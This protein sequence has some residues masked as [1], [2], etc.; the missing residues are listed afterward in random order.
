MASLISRYADW[1]H[2]RWPAGRVERLPVVGAGGETRIP[3][4]YIAG[5]LA[6]VPLLKFALDTG[7]KAA[8]RCARELRGSAAAAD[9]LD[10]V[11]LGAG[12]AGMAAAIECAK[13]GLRY[14]VV[15]PSQPFTTVANF[16]ERKPIFTY[17]RK[18]RPEGTLQ[19]SA[20]VKEDLLE[21][22][23][24]QARG[25]DIPTR[26]GSADRI[27]RRGDALAVIL[28]EG[29]PLL[30]RRVIIAIGRSGNFRRLGAPGEDLGKVSN[31]LHDPKAHAGHDVLVVGGGDSA[32]EA[33]I[34]LADAGARV[35]LCHRGAELSR[36]KPENVERLRA[37]AGAGKVALK[38]GTTVA[39]IGEREVALSSQAGG[40]RL[41]NDA[42]YA[43]IGREPPLDFFRASGIPIRGERDWRSLGG[44]GA[45]L[46]FA[47]VLYGMKAFGWFGAASWNPATIAAH[48]AERTQPGSLANVVLGSATGFGFWVTLVYSAVVVGFGIA[49]IRRRR[50]P[51]VTAQTL[52]LMAVQCLPLF[53]VPEVVLPWLG[54]HGAWDSGLGAT[55]Q[56]HLFPSVDYNFHHHE[57]WRAYGLVLAWPLFVWNVFTDQPSSW[58]LAISLVQTFVLVPLIVWK[59]GKGAYCGWI[60]SCGAL[61]E[62]MGDQQREKMG[63]GPG[64]NR[65]NFVGQALLAIAMLM[66][67][68][69]IAGWIAPERLQ[70][71]NR[72]LLYHGWKP[73]VDYALAGAVGVGLY[74]HLSGRVWCRF[75]CPLAALMHI[76]ARFSKFRIVPE[77][78]KCISCNACTTSCHQGIDVMSFANRGAAMADP[79]CVR[80]SACVQ[81]C[82]TGV[83]QF[84]EVGRDGRV[85]RLDRL[86]ASPVLMREAQGEKLE[87]GKT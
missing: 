42:V 69:R 5:D 79:E 29:E 38:L 16:P 10:V 40:E 46:A 85:L 2:L 27:E 83:L 78:A 63:H 39:S 82:P 48:L 60:C 9:A 45:F 6:G 1:L 70:A 44:L 65:L 80:C 34:A 54:Y 87:S 22:L 35:T 21:E 72:G 81:V 77:K 51:Y 86:A 14:V 43:L 11:I 32:A 30:A 20:T 58:W 19:V 68:L 4:V 15:E 62:T 36:P 26:A 50:T 41:P 33:A 66:L 53:I 23:R 61:A 56:Q 71:L 74:F 12:V 3:G 75:A 57:Y 24:R 18:M 7:A 31:R 37:L 25:F 17:P 47:V 52:T 13:Q 84:G 49:R 73:V 55:I 67:L 76:Y 59:W 28:D 64:W 8:A